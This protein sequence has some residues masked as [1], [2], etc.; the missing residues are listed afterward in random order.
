MYDVSKILLGDNPFFGIDHLSQEKARQRQ[1]RLDNL[2]KIADLIEYSLDQGVTGFVVSTHPELKHLITILNSRKNI[3]NRLD[4]YPILPYAQGYVNKVTQKGVS[5]TLNEVL[6]QGNILDKF[7]ILFSGSVGFLKKDFDKLFRTF[8]DIELLPLNHV[9]KR[10]IFLHDVVTDLAIG[11]GMKNLIQNYLTHIKQK[12]DVEPGLVTKN[13]PLLVKTMIDWNVKLPTI[14][15]SFNSVGNQMNP[16]KEACE[17]CL[18][19]NHLKIIAMNTLAG[20]L[21]KPDES[22][23]YLSKIN[24]HSVVIGMSTKE[25][26]DQITKHVQSNGE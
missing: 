2:N 3:I 8:I 7:K 1:K 25:H 15:T 16:S 14:M 13:L 6:S 12:Y 22:F 17:K 24:L 10:V 23:Q 4:F 26:I 21:L 18:E 20:G 19:D 5:G 11:L 9:R